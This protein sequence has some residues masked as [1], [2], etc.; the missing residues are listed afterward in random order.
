MPIGICTF[1]MQSLGLS[2]EMWPIFTPALIGSSLEL[3]AEIV[4]TSEKKRV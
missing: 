4:T 3:Q 2:G 1:A